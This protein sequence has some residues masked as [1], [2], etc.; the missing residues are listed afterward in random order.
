[1]GLL[2]EEKSGACSDKY[3][4][5]QILPYLALVKEKSSV[6]A[7]KITNHCKTNIWVIE[8]FLDGKFKIKDNLISW[9]P[10]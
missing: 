5:D 3:S 7:S 8:K 4:A 1:M 6:T 10:E 9:L 2:E